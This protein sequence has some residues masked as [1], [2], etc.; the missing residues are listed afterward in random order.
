[1]KRYVEKFGDYY[2]VTVYRLYPDQ[3]MQE[4]Y[5]GI[6]S[7]SYR[8][9]LAELL[10]KEISW[11][12][13]Q[14]KTLTSQELLSSPRIK[15]RDTKYKLSLP[16]RIFDDLLIC[17]VR[18]KYSIDKIKASGDPRMEYERKEGEVVIGE[19]R[20]MELYFYAGDWIKIVGIPDGVVDNLVFEFTISRQSIRHIIGRAVIYAYMCM[21]DEYCSTI[22]V[23]T[24]PGE[25]IGYL[26]IPNSRFLE[27]LSIELKEVIEEEVTG[28][29]IPFCKSCVYRNICPYS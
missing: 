13:Y 8:K 21:K 15:Y 9:R 26:I 2:G 7:T 5:L 25:E 22:I 23:P 20:R 24:T 3:P 10:R 18:C 4:E 27:Y 11:L 12:S 14:S 16:A 1:M 6:G 17:K 28:K 19:R 29:R